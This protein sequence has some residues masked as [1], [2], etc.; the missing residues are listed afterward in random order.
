VYPRDANKSSAKRTAYPVKVSE[1]RRYL[2][3]QEGKPFFYLG[4]TA[5]ELFHRL[6]REEADLYLRDRAAKRFTVIQAVVLAE[7]DGLNVPN[8]YGHSPLMDKDPTRPVEAYF[9]HVDFIVNRADQLG[10]VIG[11]LPTWGDKWNK[12]WGRGPEIFTRENAAVYGEFL[13]RRYRDKPIIWILGGDRPVENERQKAIVRA[14]AEGLKKGDGGGHLMTFHPSGGRSSAEWFQADPWLAFNMLQSGHG[15][16]HANYH[17]IARDYDQRPTKPCMDGEPGYE[18]HP[19]EFNPKNGYLDDY[20]VRKFAYWSL[21]AGAHGHT[22]GCHDIW[23]FFEPGRAPITAARTSWKTALGLPG[24]GQ[25]RHARAL[26][27]SRPFL[28]RVPDQMLLTSHPGRGTDHTRATRSQDGSYALIYSAS[29]K[30][31]T[32]DLDRLSGE[33]LRAFWYDPRRGTS[34]SIGAI[35]R[36]GRHEFQPPSQGHGHDWVLVLDAE[37]KGYSEPGQAKP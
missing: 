35:R 36:S 14:M 9:E 23:Q 17:R 5:W 18:D 11:M 8:A 31:F 7:F 27:E 25:L 28:V 15:Y 13:G 33:R 20:E 6:N 34:E 10:L 30:P 22:Y 32:V 21:F 29:G 1:N 12:K 3:D 24:A 2:I 4:D 16:D 37:S 19:A 26:L